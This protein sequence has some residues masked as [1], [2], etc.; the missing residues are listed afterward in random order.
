MTLS[1]ENQIV[2]IF[3]GINGYLDKY[4]V[5]ELGNILVSI[6]SDTGSYWNHLKNLIVSNNFA[7]SNESKYIL[8]VLL[9][10]L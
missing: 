9:Q 4:E 1:V 10:N 5:S 8:K 3:A 7:L 6:T 2:L